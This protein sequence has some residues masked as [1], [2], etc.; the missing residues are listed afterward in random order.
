MTVADLIREKGQPLKEESIPTENGKI[1]NYPGD[2]K[3]QV[4]GDIVTNSFRQPKA[5]ET[6]LLFWKNNFKECETTEKILKP[7]DHEAAEKE[8]ACPSRGLSV[9]Y[10]DGSDFVSRVIE[11]AP[12]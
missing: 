1:L 9:L 5:D 11:Y 3:F 12:Q 8:L 4:K 6:T 2:E 7:A 10:T